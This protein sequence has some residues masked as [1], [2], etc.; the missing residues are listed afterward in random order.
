MSSG[1]LEGS[2]LPGMGDRAAGQGPRQGMGTAGL[3]FSPFFPLK[4]NFK[5]QSVALKA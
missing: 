1:L 5:S 4:V 3:G 2:A